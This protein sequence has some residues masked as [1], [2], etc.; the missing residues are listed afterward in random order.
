MLNFRELL[1]RRGSPIGVAVVGATYMGTGVMNAVRRA[2]GMEVVAVFD[3]D[4]GS[5]RQAAESYAPQARMLS[6][7]ELCRESAV[8]VLVDGTSSPELGARAAALALKNG[9]HV[10]SI[11]IECDAT[12]GDALAAM[13][14]ERGSVYTV[15]A[16]DEP[17]ELK[18]LYD[19]Y[20][21][22][23]FRIVALGKGKNNPLNPRATPDDVRAGLP[24]NGITAEQ[25][26]S[27]V[28]GSK[29]MFEMACI[30]NAVGLG[31]D[32]PGMH[33]PECT[34][35]EIPQR[36]RATGS[37]GV[38]GREG[39]VDYVTGPEISGGI[40]IVV[41]CDDER[42]CS[43]FDYLKIGKGPYYVF[44]QRRHNWFVDTPLS[45]LRAALQGE[46]TVSPRARLTS[47]VVAVAKRDLKAGERLDGVGGYTAYGTIMREEDAGGLLPLG[48]CEGSVMTRDVTYGETISLSDARQPERSEVWA[49]WE[50]SERA[51]GS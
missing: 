22:L 8:E 29:T 18:V 17:G 33:G 35:A 40:W 10:V 49:L 20:E 9:K 5:A 34:I 6:L 47:R 23:G 19:H 37:G 38:L 31:P 24:D 43:D 45:I 7:E 32:V 3:P 26:A 30:G 48:L 44:Y 1:G 13:A 39:V 14:E 41:H 2:A 27:F 51:K 46:P 28:D 4:E 25:V 21:A 50:S 16:G 15:T 11:N 36:F 42:L 12:V